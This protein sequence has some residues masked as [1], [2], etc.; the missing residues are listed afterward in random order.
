MKEERRDKRKLKKELKTAFKSHHD[1]LAKVSTAENGGIQ[2]GV[3]VK[4]IY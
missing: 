2:P 4:K 1:K 3:S